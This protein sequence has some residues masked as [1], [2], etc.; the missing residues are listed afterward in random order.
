VSQGRHMPVEAVDKI[1]QGH[2]WTGER[3]QRLGLVDE[4]GGLDRAVTV[5]RSLAHLSPLERI[6]LER[7]PPRRTLWEQLFQT[8]EESRVRT[9]SA[10]PRAWLQ[11]I[12]ML[13][14]QPAW[15]VVPDVPQPW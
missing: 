13:A 1:A 6:T 4:L 9:A 10:S 8:L 2:I 5:A 3:A 7:L 15:A 11:R 14:R 12:R